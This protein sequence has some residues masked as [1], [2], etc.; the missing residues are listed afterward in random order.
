MNNEKATLRLDTRRLATKVEGIVELATQLETAVKE[1]R[2]N[3]S[4]FVDFPDG[5]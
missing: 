1:V 4:A 3:P 2:D 5:D